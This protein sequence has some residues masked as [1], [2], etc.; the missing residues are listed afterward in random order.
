MPQAAIGARIEAKS[1]E[2]RSAQ[3]RRRHRA[4]GRRIRPTEPVS[5]ERLVVNARTDSL[6]H[7]IF[8]G[9]GRR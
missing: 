5:S 9:G 4:G 2:E 3:P 1:P 6:R 8:E 7:I